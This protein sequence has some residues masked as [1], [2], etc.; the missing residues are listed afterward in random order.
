MSA[1]LSQFENFDFREL[2]IGVYMTTLD[3]QIIV[4]NRTARKMLELPIEGP[5]DANIEDYYAN[6]ADRES[7][8]E[9]SIERAKQGKNVERGI[10]HLKV[11]QRDLYVEDYSQVMKAHDGQIIG[12]V[13]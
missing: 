7:T 5:I 6:P 13:G 1:S 9:Q 2:P 11:G 8:L 4:C 3:G 12:F 10:L